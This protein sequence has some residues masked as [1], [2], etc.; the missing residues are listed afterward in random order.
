MLALRA[1]AAGA[2]ERPGLPAGVGQ[3]AAA[4]C[5]A[6]GCACE[7]RPAAA[8]H[9]SSTTGLPPAASCPCCRSRPGRR[10]MPLLRCAG[11]ASGRAR[12]GSGAQV[13]P[14]ARLAPGR[15]Q[16]SAWNRVWR[17]S[18]VLPGGPHSQLSSSS[19]TTLPEGTLPPTRPS[20]EG[21]H[22]TWLTRPCSSPRCTCRRRAAGEAGEGDGAK[23]LQQQQPPEPPPGR[24]ASA[25]ERRGADQRRR[26]QP[27]A[28]CSLQP[29]AARPPA[30][31]AVGGPGV[32]AAARVVPLHPASPHRHLLQPAAG[33]QQH[34]VALQGQQPLDH[35]LAR[36]VGRPAAREGGGGA[37]RGPRRG[38][39]GV[40]AAPWKRRRLGGLRLGGCRIW[41]LPAPRTTA[42]RRRRGGACA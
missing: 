26:Q 32:G 2:L 22:T 31:R 37:R 41:G 23:Q 12:A 34:H 8:L 13:P 4:S 24:P 28:A 9:L 42:S 3:P 17:R 35:L 36:L 14:G 39:G 6:A 1:P 19:M 18:Q 11:L 29:A 20:R 10:R 27:A 21:G 15:A 25:S 5:S 40:W 33:R 30:H 38:V 16:P 7:P